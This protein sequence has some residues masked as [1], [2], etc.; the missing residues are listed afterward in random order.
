MKHKITLTTEEC[1]EVVEILKQHI[2]QKNVD[3]DLLSAFKKINIKCSVDYSKV[4]FDYV[5]KDFEPRR[6]KSNADIQR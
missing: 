5:I 6:R 4:N 3:K 1:F 2:E